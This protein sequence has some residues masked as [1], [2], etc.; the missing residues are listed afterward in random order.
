M[1]GSIAIIFSLLSFCY[2]ACTRRLNSSYCF[3]YSSSRATTLSA[4]FY[5]A[6]N[7]HMEHWTYSNALHVLQVLP[8]DIIFCFL[9]FLCSLVQIYSH[10]KNGLLSVL[11]AI[12]VF[13]LFILSDN[14]NFL[15]LVDIHCRSTRFT[16]SIKVECAIR[17]TVLW[18]VQLRV[19]FFG[20]DLF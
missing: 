5:L 10:S 1:L 17:L 4:L 19:V 9:L 2:H 3:Y 16:R 7:L 11:D 18:L 14:S 8:D 13:I 20:F 15:L 6:S 12:I